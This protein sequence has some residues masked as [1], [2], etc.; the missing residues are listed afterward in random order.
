MALA[1]IAV[2]EGNR[3]LF[4]GMDVDGS[5]SSAEV[6]RM[7]ASPVILVVDCTKVRPHRSPRMARLQ[8]RR[9]AICKPSSGSDTQSIAALP[10]PRP[11][12]ST[13]SA[14]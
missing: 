12:A 2:I 8:A 1:D 4:D 6:A 3:G 10:R 13:S 5:C 9:N 7:L 11:M 14:I